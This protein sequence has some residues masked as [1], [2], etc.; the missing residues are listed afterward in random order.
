MDV[1][2]RVCLRYLLQYLHCFD[3]TPA[4]MLQI[5]ASGRLATPR[6]KCIFGSSHMKRDKSA[7]ASNDVQANQSLVGSVHINSWWLLG[8]SCEKHMGCTIFSR[9]AAQTTV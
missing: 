3:V 5:C 4:N 9:D 2:A 8:N 6:K 7:Y 1:C